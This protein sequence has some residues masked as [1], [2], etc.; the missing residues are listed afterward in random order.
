MSEDA[1]E[2]IMAL[3]M[4]LLEELK[5]EQMNSNLTA[6]N[7]PYDRELHSMQTFWDLFSSGRTTQTMTCSE[8]SNVT[9]RDDDFSEIMLKFPPLQPSAEN[10]RVKTRRHTLANLYE[11]Y[12]NEVIND[13]ICIPCNSRTSAT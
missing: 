4:Y 9:S 12:T 10:T 11:Y 7:H 2:Y 6:S 1:H 13:F 5:P 3:K 8:C